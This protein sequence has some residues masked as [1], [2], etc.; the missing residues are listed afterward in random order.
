MWQAKTDYVAQHGTSFSHKLLGRPELLAK[1]G[2]SVAPIANWMMDRKLIR[3]PMEFVTGID[4]KTNLPKFHSR[5]LRRW[6]KKYDG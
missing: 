5:T 2:T 1:L 6:F 3:I 4:R